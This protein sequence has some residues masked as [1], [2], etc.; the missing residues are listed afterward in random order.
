MSVL[1]VFHSVYLQQKQSIPNTNMYFIRKYLKT[2][3]NTCA[4]AFPENPEEKKKDLYILKKY[5]M[6][7]LRKK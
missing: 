2:N 1:T 3:R 6:A 5:R 4:K 7:S